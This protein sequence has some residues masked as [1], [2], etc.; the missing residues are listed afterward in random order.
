[1]SDSTALVLCRVEDGLLELA[2]LWEA[3]PK[4]KGW[5]VPGGEV[6]AALAGVMERYKVVRGYFDPPLWQSE[7]DGWAREYGDKSVL[8]YYTN[9]PRMMPAVERFRT[10]VVAGQSGRARESAE[11]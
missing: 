8:R 6:D 5:E 7:V 10:D 2:G 1:V 4:G 3:P 9:K 11:A